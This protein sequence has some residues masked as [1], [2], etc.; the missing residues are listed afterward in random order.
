MKWT[1]EV[2]PTE[3]REVMSLWSINLSRP[4]FTTP[5]NSLA[6]TP[7]R[8]IHTSPE[9]LARKVRTSSTK[10]LQPQ[11]QALINSL[12]WMRKRRKWG[13]N[14]K[15]SEMNNTSAKITSSPEAHSIN[16]RPCSHPILTHLANIS[17]HSKCLQV[18]VIS[19]TRLSRISKLS[20]R[21]WLLI[22]EALPSTP[23]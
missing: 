16:N 21:K 13:S 14:S 1:A 8:I 9:I 5:S 17:I 12:T 18:S 2:H 3:M 20:C 23:L 19:L 6:A 4:K 7:I 10:T 22:W 15:C 11:A